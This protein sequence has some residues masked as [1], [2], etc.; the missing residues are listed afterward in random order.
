MVNVG[1]GRIQ[2]VTGDALGN[3]I[4]KNRHG[5]ADLIAQNDQRFIAVIDGGGGIN[6]LYKVVQHVIHAVS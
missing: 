1:V 4:V 3:G 5:V 2:T 6:T